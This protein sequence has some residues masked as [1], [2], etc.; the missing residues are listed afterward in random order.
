MPPRNGYTLGK[1]KKKTLFIEEK[2]AESLHHLAWR[3]MRRKNDD[4]T[5]RGQTH[6]IAFHFYLPP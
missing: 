3:I 2:N 1:R 4:G 6:I 5:G